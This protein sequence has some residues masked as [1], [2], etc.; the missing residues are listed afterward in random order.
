MACLAGFI[1]MEQGVAPWLCGGFAY[2]MGHIGNKLMDTILVALRI[3]ER[4]PLKFAAS[5]I[6]LIWQYLIPP[7]NN[8]GNQ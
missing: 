3:A 5:V 7:T 4:D 8:N 1:A 2:I 6:A